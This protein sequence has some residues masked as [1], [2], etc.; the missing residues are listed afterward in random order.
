M[1]FNL[2]RAQ[3]IGVIGSVETVNQGTDKEFSK[4]SVACN[5]QYTNRENE[6]V[7][8]TDWVE[9]TL[10]KKANLDNYVKGRKVYVEGTPTV[11]SYVDA[12]GKAVGKLRIVG[13]RIIFQDAKPDEV[14]EESH[15]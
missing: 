8:T 4:I 14:S 1:H 11:N 3:I 15:E 7:T 13:A 9:V 10:S 12:E 2:F 6:V 5:G